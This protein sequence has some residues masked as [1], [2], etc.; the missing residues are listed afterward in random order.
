M[1]TRR[2]PWAGVKAEPIPLTWTDDGV[3]VPGDNPGA[4]VAA[5]LV[6]ENDAVTVCAAIRDAAAAGADVPAARTGSHS[7]FRILRTF[8]SFA[9]QFSESKT[10][11]ER[12][13]R[14]VGNTP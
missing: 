14:A 8:P 7:A 6:A 2:N 12:F 9:D 11:K 3:L 5:D 10:D 1:T 13:W 4:R